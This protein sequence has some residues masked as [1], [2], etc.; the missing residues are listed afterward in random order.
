MG[1][2]FWVAAI[3]FNVLNVGTESA[4]MTIVRSHHVVKC[5]NVRC[6]TH[7]TGALRAVFGVPRQ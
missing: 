5:Q 1:V 6:L 2:V 4:G 7:V 3:D